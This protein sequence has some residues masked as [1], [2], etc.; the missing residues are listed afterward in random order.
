MLLTIDEALRIIAGWSRS[1]R[2]VVLRDE[3][4]LGN[5]KRSSGTTQ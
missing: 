3:P 5:L 4:L 2:K 1:N